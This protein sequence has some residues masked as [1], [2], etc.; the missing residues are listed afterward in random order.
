MYGS[1]KSRFFFRSS[2]ISR[3]FHN[4]SMRPLWISASLLAQ[5]MPLNSTSVPRRFAASFASSTS[6]PVIS[7]FSSRK[8]IG[9]KL[10]SRPMTIFFGAS[11][12]AFCPP[13]PAIR[14]AA[15]MSDKQTNK[16]FFKTKHSF[17][18]LK[19]YHSDIIHGQREFAKGESR[20]NFR[21]FDAQKRREGA[22][23][24]APSRRFTESCLE[25]HG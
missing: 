23:F 4:A 6:K 8:P 25:K 1:E 22:Q 15:S 7:F 11:F 16:I 17:S 21:L 19:Y 10:S 20:H 18:S 24:P 2:V 3:P 9:G 13:H 14:P 5:S 12:A